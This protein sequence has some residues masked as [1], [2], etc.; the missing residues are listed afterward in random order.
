MPKALAAP[1][2]PS[3][4]EMVPD[5]AA[6]A[7]TLVPPPLRTVEVE[8]PAPVV[9]DLDAIVNAS[10]HKSLGAEVQKNPELLFGPMAAALSSLPGMNAVAI[11]TRLYE[12][13][14]VV[15]EACEWVSSGKAARQFAIEAHLKALA[16]KSAA[17]DK[18]AADLADESRR[19]RGSIAGLNND[20]PIRAARLKRG[21]ALMAEA[22]KLRD[23]CR[24]IE[25]EIGAIR[26][27]AAAQA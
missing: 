14:R 10:P 21:D 8:K 9:V 16:A 2:L 6:V 24:A 3:V 5:A 13:Y 1:T 20:D 19:A 25:A 18:A 4:E 22:V 23:E 27:A 12:N 26:M 11:K 7:E 17:T 15:L